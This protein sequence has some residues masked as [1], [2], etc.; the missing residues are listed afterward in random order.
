MVMVCGRHG[1]GSPGIAIV[2]MLHGCSRQRRTIGSFAATADFLVLFSIS[3][4]GDG[5]VW[6]L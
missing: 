3:K 6:V 2:S 5:D 4:N 1:I